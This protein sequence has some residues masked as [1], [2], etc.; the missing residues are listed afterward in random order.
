MRKKPKL[1][2]GTYYFGGKTEILE[3]I[4]KF[5]VIKLPQSFTRKVH[6]SIF[7]QD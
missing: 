4:I 3:K 6:D 1:K 5:L 2:S 7:F